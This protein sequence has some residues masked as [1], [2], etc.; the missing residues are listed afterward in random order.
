MRQSYEPAIAANRFG[1]GARPG[2][3]AHIGADPR[4]YLRSQLDGPAPLLEDAA[5][6]DSA[7]IISR[8]LALRHERAQARAEAMKSGEPPQL[9]QFQRI[10]QYYRTLYVSEAAARLRFAC[11]SDRSFVER[12]TQFWTNHFAIS[13]D[14]AIVLGVAGAFEREAIRP[15]VLGNF[16]D[17]LLRVEHHPAMLLYLDNYLS[18][19][20]NAPLARLARLRPKARVGINENLAREILELHTLGVDG[21]YSQSDVT[22]FAYVLSGWSIGGERGLLSRG[23]P[24]R[25]VFR[26]GMHEPGARQLLGRRYAEG[27]VEQGEA[28]LRDLARHP[29]TAHHIATKLARHFIADDPPAAAIERIARVFL[30]SGGEL[31]QVYGALIDS[32]EAWQQP[33]AKFKTPAE[34][35]VSAHRGLALPVPEGQRALGPLEQLG[36]RTYA[37]GSPAGWPDRAGD[38]DS[39]TALLKRVEWADAIGER[40]ADRYDAV[41]LAPQWFGAALSSTTRSALA[42]AASASQGLTLLLSSPEFLRR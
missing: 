23:E 10:A 34:Y 22:T 28:V 36:Q 1:L 13:V 20:P 39:A 30:S 26:P 9:A 29:A 16:T 37:P 15:H 2:D 38:W 41:A 4:A 19:G 40:L 11:A 5:L 14:K 3:L 17:L 35:I 18:V 21:G 31:P 42:H 6:A 33:F 24:G 27:G 32:R 12:L 8:T 7:Q 25:F